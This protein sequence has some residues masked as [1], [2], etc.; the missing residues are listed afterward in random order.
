MSCRG[1]PD[2]KYFVQIAEPSQLASFYLFAHGLYK[3]LYVRQPDA[4]P[5]KVMSMWKINKYFT[6]I[7]YIFL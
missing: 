3:L 4:K 2:S 1:N 6:L 5:M 7:L